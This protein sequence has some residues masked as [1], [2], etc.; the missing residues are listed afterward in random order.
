M[1]FSFFNYILISIFLTRSSSSSSAE[2]DEPKS[3]KQ[4][5]HKKEKEKGKKHKYKKGKHH[6][7]EKKKRR[8]EKSSSSNSS[9]SS[10]SDWDAGLFL[11]SLLQRLF[12]FHSKFIYVLQCCF[13]MG[14]IYI[15]FW[16]IYLHTSVL[17]I[18]RWTIYEKNLLFYFRFIS[19]KPCKF[20]W[21]FT[22]IFSSVVIVFVIFL[23]GCGKFQFASLCVERY[24]LKYAWCQSA[25]IKF[26]NS[27]E[28][29][30]YPLNKCMFYTTFSAYIH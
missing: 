19:T 14:D 15:F 23:V 20:S 7:K 2:E 3:K 27:S 8:K 26:G 21:F 5:S 25:Y 12:S 24:G 11:C 16:E 4:K 30:Y 17:Q 1:S 13:K 29:F 22:L 18:I 9:D 28:I 10:S 6:K